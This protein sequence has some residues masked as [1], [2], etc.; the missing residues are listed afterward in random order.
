MVVIEGDI[1]IAVPKIKARY[2]NYLNENAPVRGPG[3][4]CPAG[5][6]CRG[7]ACDQV[8]DGDAG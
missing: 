8:A 2:F 7:A 1:A 5:N 3:H 6:N 4:N